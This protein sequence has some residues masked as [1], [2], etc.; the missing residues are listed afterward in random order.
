MKRILSTLFIILFS[1]FLV[2]ADDP[3][4]LDADIA[5]INTYIPHYC[6]ITLK[7]YTNLST[8]GGMPFD[9]TED[10][11]KYV[12]STLTSGNGGW[13]IGTWS[14]EANMSGYDLIVDATPLTC[15]SDGTELG[16]HLIFKYSDTFFIVNVPASASVSYTGTRPSIGPLNSLNKDVL[17]MFDSDADIDAAPSGSYIGTITLTLTEI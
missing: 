12:A 2:F 15:T 4:L 6:L 10:R 9:I 1:C 16:Y 7:P 17:F 13:K 5:E 8:T 11:A 14:L 3:T